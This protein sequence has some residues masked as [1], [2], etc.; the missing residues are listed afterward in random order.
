MT[1]TVSSLFSMREILARTSAVLWQAFS[2]RSLRL[3]AVVA[4]SLAAG[5][6]LQSTTLIRINADGSGTIEQTTIMT[7]AALRQLRQLAAMGGD[8]GKPI[9]FFSTKQAHDMAASL[10]PGVTVVSST[11][12][13]NADGEGSKAIF[14]FADIGQLDIK[15]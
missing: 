8:T 13:K 10:G 12:I 9:D 2:M 1:A 15:Q 4:A 14:A 7:D 11:R 6:C 5:A 3:A